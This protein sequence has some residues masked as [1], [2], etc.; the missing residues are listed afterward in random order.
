MWHEKHSDV[1]NTTEVLKKKINNNVT[2]LTMLIS[3][4]TSSISV[5]VFSLSTS[6]KFHKQSITLNV[7]Y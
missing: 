4:I 2:M 5:L 6:W 1:K 7:E 3:F